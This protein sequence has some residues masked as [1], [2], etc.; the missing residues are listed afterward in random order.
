MLFK[1]ID[2]VEQVKYAGFSGEALI[3]RD[4]DRNVVSKDGKDTKVIA[5]NVEEFMLGM[6]FVFCVT[7]KENDLQVY[8]KGE[9]VKQFEGPFAFMPFFDNGDWVVVLKEAEAGE[10]F[11]RLDT[12]LNAVAYNWENSNLV[13][14]KGNY[15]F[16][17]RGQIFSCHQVS[18]GHELWNFDVYE[19]SGETEGTV[20]RDLIVYNDRLFLG[21]VTGT[22]LCLEVATGKIIERISLGVGR[23]KYYEGRIYGAEEQK[24]RVLDPETLQVNRIDLATAFKEQGFSIVTNMF[25]PQGDELYFKNE[26]KPVIGVVKLSTQELL[27]HSEIPI[28]EGNYW[29]DDLGVQGDKLY[30]LTQGGTLRIFEKQK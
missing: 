15:F 26:N 21:L 10:Q 8:K 7:K 2:T 3:Y 6:S 22:V 11:I 14:I 24:V 17:R 1:L 18:D 28:E 4:K 5:R 20:T 9:L 25:V 16:V 23:I 30:V 27:W 29:I 12:A 13:D 19:V